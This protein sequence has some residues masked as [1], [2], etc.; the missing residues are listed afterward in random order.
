MRAVPSKT[1]SG[2]VAGWRDVS[3][4]N[5][6]RPTRRY[7]LDRVSSHS[8]DAEQCPYEMMLRCNSRS[9]TARVIQHLAERMRRWHGLSECMGRRPS[10]KSSEDRTVQRARASSYDPSAPQ[11][12]IREQTR[13]PSHSCTFSLSSPCPGLHATRTATTSRRHVARTLASQQ[14]ALYFPGHQVD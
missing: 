10:R 3:N 13:S 12:A 8:F 6:P 2:S 1:G 7:R 14:F 4:F 9:K 5:P 11:R